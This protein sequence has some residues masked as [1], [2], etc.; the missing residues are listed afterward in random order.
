[1]ELAGSLALTFD[2]EGKGGRGEED[3]EGL[4]SKGE[5]EKTANGLAN[6]DFLDIWRQKEKN[7]NKKKETKK[8]RKKKVY[9]FCRGCCG[10]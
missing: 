9:R 1:M 3:Q 5:E 10:R 8:E 7:D 4:T 2:V 6:D